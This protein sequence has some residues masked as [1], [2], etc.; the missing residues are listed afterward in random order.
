MFGA[1]SVLITY[2]T[3]LYLTVAASAQSTPLIYNDGSA[4]VTTELVPSWIGAG[5]SYLATFGVGFEAGGEAATLSTAPNNV[6]AVTNSPFALAST[7]LFAVTVGTLIAAGY[8]IATYTDA[9]NPV[10]AAKA[11]LTVVPAYLV[12][13]VLAAVLMSHNY[14]DAA[15]VEQIVGSVSGLEA[16]Q[17]VSGGEITGDV[18]FGPSLTD[19]VLFAGIVFPA[20]FAVLGAVL[21]QGRSTVDAVVDKVN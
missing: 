7:T 19:S 3:H 8:G 10:E 4:T 17:F 15:L 14:S 2:L 20:V 1:G 16:E 13:A 21:S 11:G 6:A 5:W 12:F 18:D 9:E